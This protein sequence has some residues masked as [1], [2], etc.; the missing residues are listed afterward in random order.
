VTRIAADGRIE[1]DCEKFWL[2]EGDGDGK[3]VGV[4]SGV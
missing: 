2:V 1:F 4:I 3:G